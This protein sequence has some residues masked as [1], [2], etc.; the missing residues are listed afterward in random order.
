LSAKNGFYAFESALHAFSLGDSP[1]EAGLIT[2]NSPEGWRRNYERLDGAVT[3]FAQDAF[4]YQFGIFNDRVWNFDPETGDLNLHS[5]CVEDWAEKILGD[6]DYEV[7]W[8]ACSDWQKEHGPLPRGYRLLPKLP[9]VAGGEYKAPNLRSVS[10]MEAMEK[11]GQL[12]LGL[13]DLPDGTTFTL[14]GW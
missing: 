9:F 1:F 13:R 11:Y 12:Y 8:T 14:E 7:G 10:S 2:W 3:F 4:G 5:E 6:Y